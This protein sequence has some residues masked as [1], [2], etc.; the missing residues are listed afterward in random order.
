MSDLINRFRKT[1]EE[2]LETARTNAQTFKETAE[3]YS[4]VARLRFDL[5]Q[6]KSSRRKKMELLGETVYPFL[7][8]NNLNGIK[9][10]E[11]LFILIDDIKNI[12]NEIELTQKAL[13]GMTAKTK[14][15]E[16]DEQ[17][18]QLRNQISDLEKE[19]ESRLQEIKIV[20][21]ALDKK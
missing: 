5:H 20:K 21:E 14:P 19:I 8:E 18:E 10:H 2:T 12:S 15:G 7:M 1:I 13:L 6:L 3:E 17:H 9:K 16:D 4:K 11:T